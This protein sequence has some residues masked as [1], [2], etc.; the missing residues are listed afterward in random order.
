VLG[1]Y[2]AFGALRIETKETNAAARRGVSPQCLCNSAKR[3][4]HKASFNFAAQSETRSTEA[5][6]IC[7]DDGN[8]RGSPVR[9]SQERLQISV[10]C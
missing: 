10:G 4:C 6:R 5:L 3:R 8:S 9:K 7:W 1:T 2:R